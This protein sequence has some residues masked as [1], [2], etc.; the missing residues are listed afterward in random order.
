MDSYIYS[1]TFDVS[2]S[3][4]ED[5]SKD[6]MDPL[7]DP[8]VTVAV[9]VLMGNMFDDLL[10][11][12]VSHH[13]FT[14]NSP[15]RSVAT[16]SMPIMSPRPAVSP[17]APVESPCLPARGRGIAIKNWKHERIP[18]NV[19]KFEGADIVLPIQAE[20]RKTDMTSRVK[21][22]ANN[23][24]SSKHKMKLHIELVPRPRNPVVFRG[25]DSYEFAD[26]FFLKNKEKY[27]WK[28]SFHHPLRLPGI[29]PEM[30]YYPF[31]EWPYIIQRPSI[32][33]YHFIRTE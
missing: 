14:L 22:K 33:L 11:T 10:S 17:L 9:S 3:M 23:P 30:S 16:T 8:L 20:I 26:E 13:M 25:A 19:R 24:P 27:C 28:T 21:G 32:K 18:P 15:K 2:T 5:Y 31:C 29:P 4:A 12:R 1:P 6:L 7:I